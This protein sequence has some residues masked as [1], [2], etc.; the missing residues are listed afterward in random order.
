M[1]KV[2]VGRRLRAAL[3]YIQNE[4]AAH[5]AG[6]GRKEME[7]AID[8][9]AVVILIV[10]HALAAQA[11]SGLLVPCVDKPKRARVGGSKKGATA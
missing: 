3:Q 8:N 10:N 6:R 4:I 5:G 2:I 9:S 7:D 11:R 1:S